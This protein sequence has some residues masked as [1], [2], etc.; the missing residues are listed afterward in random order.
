MARCA[1]CGTSDGACGARE[2]E[3]PVFGEEL[4]Q[5][6]VRVEATEVETPNERPI[7]DVQED[8]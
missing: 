4:Q 3:K 6:T 1:I 8:D 7:V 2:L 5:A